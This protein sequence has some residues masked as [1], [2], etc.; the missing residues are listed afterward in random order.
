[1]NLKQTTKLLRKNIEIIKRTCDSKPEK[2]IGLLE[3]MLSSENGTLNQLEKASEEVMLEKSQSRHSNESMFEEVPPKCEN[4]I[5]QFCK[6]VY[7]NYHDA[8]ERFENQICQNSRVLVCPNL[9]DLQ[10]KHDYNNSIHEK[11]RLVFVEWSCKTENNEA[12]SN[13][14]EAVNSVYRKI[15][16]GVDC[17]KLFKVTHSHGILELVAIA[18]SDTLKYKILEEVQFIEE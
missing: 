12:K 17:S 18:N 5:S 7:H 3:E 16:V 14:I 10:E 11:A 13:L 9:E 8:V 1:M 6:L 2:V 15:L 4:M